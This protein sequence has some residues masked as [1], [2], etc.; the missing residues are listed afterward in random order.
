MCL[1]ECK[2]IFDKTSTTFDIH[3]KERTSDICVDI[4][5]FDSAPLF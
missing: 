3:L 2:R 5:F 1:Y 4:C